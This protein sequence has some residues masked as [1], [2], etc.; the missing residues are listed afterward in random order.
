MTLNTL[1]KNFAAD[2]TAAVTQEMMVIAAAGGF[3]SIAAMVYVLGGVE[4]LEDD[5]GYQLKVQEKVTTF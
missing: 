3:L 4:Q 2:E 5:T 1:I